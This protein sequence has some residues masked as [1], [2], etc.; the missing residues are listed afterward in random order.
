MWIKT[1]KAEEKRGW[2]LIANFENDVT[3]TSSSNLIQVHSIKTIYILK[4]SRTLTRRVKG[5]IR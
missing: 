5:G 2:I 1:R 3:I 4:N